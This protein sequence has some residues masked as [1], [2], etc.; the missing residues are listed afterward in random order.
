VFENGVLR[1]IFGFKREV[2]VGGWSRLHNVEPNKLYTLPNIIRVIKS[3]MTRWTGHV[4]RIGGDEDCIQY[5]D[6]KT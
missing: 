5:F 6:W 3:R 4:A 2:V 1:R